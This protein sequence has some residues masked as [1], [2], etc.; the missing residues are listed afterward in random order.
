MTSFCIFMGLL[1]S[2]EQS[3]LCTRCYSRRGSIQIFAIVRNIALNLYREQGFSNIP[4]AQR[5]CLQT[6]SALVRI[7]RIK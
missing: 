7:F 6:L 5:F 4:K 1:G 2:G 3:L